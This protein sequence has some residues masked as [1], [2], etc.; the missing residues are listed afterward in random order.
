M[1]AP[2]PGGTEL[3]DVTAHLDCVRSGESLPRAR[4]TVLWEERGGGAGGRW[5]RR[6]RLR[7]LQRLQ[8][9]ALHA[10]SG[11]QPLCVC[12]SFLNRRHH[13]RHLPVLLFVFPGCPR[14]TPVDLHRS[15]A[16]CSRWTFGDRFLSSR[17]TRSESGSTAVHAIS[18]PSVSSLKLS[19]ATSSVM[20]R[21]QRPNASDRMRGD[22]EILP[23]A[24][25]PPP[26]ASILAVPTTGD[27]KPSAPRGAGEEWTRS[28][29]EHWRRQSE[30]LAAVVC[31]IIVWQL[32]I[33]SRTATGGEE[34]GRKGRGLYTRPLH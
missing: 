28:V 11:Y 30:A 16:R 20:T 7:T 4:R 22:R 19:G 34:E 21:P 9:S 6:R 17:K 12:I 29:F 25:A 23:P 5:N 2:W 31:D 33:R 27:W 24:F 26:C 18:K 13:L 10:S 32:M 3:S 8:D 14:T 15:T 1:F